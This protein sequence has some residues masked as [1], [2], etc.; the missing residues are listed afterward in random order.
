V[1]RCHIP[2]R[3]LTWSAV[4]A[5][6]PRFGGGWCRAAP[7]AVSFSVLD[8]RQLGGFCTRIEGHVVGEHAMQDDSELA[9]QC[10]LRLGHAGA[11]GDP[12]RPALE[13]RTPLDRPRQPIWSYVNDTMTMTHV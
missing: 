11:L 6:G 9:R 7:K 5:K 8:R 4:P 2:D 10:N 13:L 3:G 1:V 12:H